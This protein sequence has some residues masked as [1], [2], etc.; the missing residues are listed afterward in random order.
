MTAST[1]RCPATTAVVLA[2]PLAVLLGL[3]VLT[4]GQ[5]GWLS[6]QYW[7]PT[8]VVLCVF[9]AL[10]APAVMTCSLLRRRPGSSSGWRRLLRMETAALIVA[11]PLGL[12]T[13]CAI[14]GGA[15]I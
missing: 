6:V 12:L 4:W 5:Q 11:V 2:P 13:I 3:E 15:V 8:S 9:Y 1:C 7:S 10:A 14:A